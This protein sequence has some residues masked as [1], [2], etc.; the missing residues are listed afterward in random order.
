MPRE[1][2]PAAPGAAAAPLGS[3]ARRGWLKGTLLEGA[4]QLS[5]HAAVLG[6]RAAHAASPV[7]DAASPMFKKLAAATGEASRFALDRVQQG[8]ETLQDAQYRAAAAA[9][10]V[11]PPAPVNDPRDGSAG[12]SRVTTKFSSLSWYELQLLDETRS[13]L[14]QLGVGVSD[15]VPAGGRAASE[16]RKSPR[17]SPGPPELGEKVRAD[18]VV[19]W[20]KNTADGQDDEEAAYHLAT[21][22]TP[23]A[24]AEANCCYV[25]SAEFSVTRYRHHCRACG[26][27]ICGDHSH[28]EWHRLPHLG[29]KTPQRVCVLCK[30]GL[31]RRDLL[32][33]VEWRVARVQAHVAGR[34][35]PYFETASDPHDQKARRAVDGVITAAKYTP[36]SVSATVLVETIDLLR[37]YGYTGLAGLVMHREFLEAA[38]LLKQVAGVDQKWPLPV[39][40]L[41]ASLYY[42]VGAARRRRGNDPALERTHHAAQRPPSDA[43][44]EDLMFFAPLALHFLYSGGGAT[45]PC[46]A[47]R[48]AALQG[49]TLVY[50]KAD[51]ELYHPAFGLFVHEQRRVACLA[52]RG[53]ATVKDVVTDIKARPKR[54]PPTDEDLD[55]PGLTPPRMPLAET[56][57][58]IGGADGSERMAC[59]GMAIAAEWLAAETAA[60]L[61]TLQAKGYRVV[62]TG[63]SLGGAVATLLAVLLRPVLP[64]V[65]AVGFSTPSCASEALARHCRDFATHVVLHDDVIPRITPRGLRRIMD[66]VLRQEHREAMQKELKRDLSAVQERIYSVWAPRKRP[67]VLKALPGAPAARPPGEGEGG[68]EDGGEGG[69]GGEGGGGGRPGRRLRGRRLR[70]RGGR[71]G[72]LGRRRRAPRGHARGVRARRRAAHLQRARAVLRGL[73]AL[74]LRG[75]LHHPAAAAHAE[76]PCCVERVG[77]AARG[78]RDAVARRAPSARLAAAPRE[79]RVR[80]LPLALHLGEHAAVGDAGRAR[81]AQLQEV[82][83]A[84]LRALLHGAHRAAGDG[85]ARAVPRVRPLPLPHL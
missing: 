73:G 11:P 70:G 50:V 26:K 8:V 54:F 82:R 29:Y 23:P 32:Q 28:R 20:L 27:S 51:S 30:A 75:P 13:E 18:L 7:M 9:G 77:R 52:V 63:H 36:L 72:S 33:R 12:W 21:L 57:Q 55:L 24:P 2:P 15:V 45:V 49:W 10:R 4:A 67:S 71:R 78:L 43:D 44:L 79:R 22:V 38:E 39:H 68:E 47:Q 6:S 60:S 3:A 41:S 37:R 56:W 35:V 84:L 14:A 17:C 80:M 58:H 1:L 40:E 69:E 42:L 19:E 81:Q 53:T 65:R 83:P 85:P 76:R 34:L 64:G 48:L 59:S 25:C 16:E 62:T 46:E 66:S 5:S 61:Q 74:R 31:V